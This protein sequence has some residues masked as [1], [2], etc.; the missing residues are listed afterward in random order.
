LSPTPDSVGPV[1]LCPTPHGVG[2]VPAVPNT[3]RCWSRDCRAQHLT[4]LEPSLRL[5]LAPGTRR[6][7]VRWRRERRARC[8]RGAIAFRTSAKRDPLP[9]RFGSREAP[10]ARRLTERPPLRRA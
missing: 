8:A 10:A 4:V 1:L 2:A 6:G 7:A 5:P 9:C 3:S